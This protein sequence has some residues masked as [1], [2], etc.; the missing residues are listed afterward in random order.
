[1]QTQ[2]YGLAEE[3]VNAVSH[4]LAALLSIA[5]LTLLVTLAWI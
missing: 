4:G 5:G 1:M 2:D 3:I